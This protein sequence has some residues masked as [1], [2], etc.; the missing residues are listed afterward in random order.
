MLH[1]LLLTAEFFG[2]QQITILIHNNNLSEEI[3]IFAKILL[4]CDFVNHKSRITWREIEAGPPLREPAE[5][6]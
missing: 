1:I 4:Q 5:L 3:E 2:H 6:W